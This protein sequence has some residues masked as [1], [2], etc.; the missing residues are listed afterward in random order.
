MVFKKIFFTISVFGFL[1]NYSSANN[2][3][4]KQAQSV[5]KEIMYTT[6]ECNPCG[7]G[8]S[9]TRGIIFNYYNL[10][11][12]T[13][14]L[15]PRSD[16]SPSLSLC[17]SCIIAGLIGLCTANPTAT[18]TQLLPYTCAVHTIA[19]NASLNEQFKPIISDMEKNLKI[20]P[21]FCASLQSRMKDI[22]E[23][24]NATGGYFPKSNKME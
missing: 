2:S 22:Q 1:T 10:Q 23:K 9:D 3:P 16:F 20:T 15:K 4:F 17:E 11:T 5:I 7:L 13:N 21:P 12:P 24:C 18:C 8:M 19:T 6:I 14:S